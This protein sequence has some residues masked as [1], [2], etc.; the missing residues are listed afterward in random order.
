[1]TSPKL[2]DFA[3]R[4]AYQRHRH[5]L[6]QEAVAAHLPPSRPGTN[7]AQSTIG[8]WENDEGNSSPTWKQIVALCKLFSVSAD[9]LLGLSESESGLASDA[10]I[11]DEAAEAA[12]R[13]DPAADPHRVLMKVPRRHRVIDYETAQKLRKELKLDKV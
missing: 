1:M 12:R 8:D 5:G 2:S 7:P 4:L 3:S 6:T 11:V 9:Y 10:F 13:A